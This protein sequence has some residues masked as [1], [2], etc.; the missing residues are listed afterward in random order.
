MNE[1]VYRLRETLEEYVRSTFETD[2]IAAL[3]R[4]N[5]PENYQQARPRVEIKV[6]LGGATGRRFLCPD[7][8]IRF[9]AFYFTL[10]IQCITTPNKPAAQ[11]KLAEDFVARVRD[12]CS[13]FA[14]NTWNDLTHFPALYIAERLKDTGTNDSRIEN[15]VEY[16]ILSFSGIVGIRQTAWQ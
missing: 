1:A 15:G 14:Q 12:F 3:T 5:Q 6:S 4:Q 8:I 9:D 2:G 16:S 7:S 13:S 11:N 10:A